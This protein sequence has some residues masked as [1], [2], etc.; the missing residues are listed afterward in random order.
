MRSSKDES[1]KMNRATRIALHLFLSIFAFYS[2]ASA[3][4]IP[5]PAPKPNGGRNSTMLNVDFRKLVSHADLSYNEPASRSEEGLP[6]GNGRMGSLVWTSPSALKFQIN[7]AD[8]FAENSSTHSFPERHG[9]YASGC[10]F[11]DIDFVDYG[12]EVFAGPAFHQDLSVYDALMTLRGNGVSARVLTWNEHDVIAVEVDD[13]REQPSPINIDLRML[14]RHIVQV[15]TR[16][17]SASSKLDI[18]NGR[19]ALTQEFKEG[20][21]YDSSAVVIGMAGRESKSRY[22]NDSTVRLSAAPGKGRF[23]ILIASAASFDPNQDVASRAVTQ[24]EQAAA[25]GFDAM[26]ASNQGWWHDFWSKAFVHLH[27]QDGVADEV[28][29]NYTYFLYLMGITSRGA[30]PPRFGGML[31]YT[32]GDMR[33]WGSQYWWANESCYYNA[34]PAVNRFELMDPMFAMYSGMYDSVSLA[35]AQQ[36]GSKGIFIPEVVWFDGLEKLP[37]DIAAEMRDL[38]LGRKLWEKRSVSFRELAD[39]KQPHS[40]RWNWIDAGS[41]VNGKWVYKDKGAGPYGQVNHIF[42][43]QAKIAHLYW[44]RYEYSQDKV[45]L[46]ERAYP[47]LKGVAEF[48]RNYPNVKKDADGKYHIHDINGHEPIWGA[49]DTLEEVA[50][51]R[52]IVPLAIRASEI[53]DVDPELRAAWREF[54]QNLAPLPTSDL[55]AA[56]GLVKDGGPRRWI[57]GLPPVQKGNLEAPSLAPANYYDL[58]TIESDDAELVKT[59]NATYDAIYPHGVDE[60][61]AINVLNRN[62]AAA[63]HLGRAEDLRH[64]LPNQLNCLNPARDFCD[65]SG[66]GSTRVL[67]NRLTLREGPGATEAER[68]GRVAEALQLALLQSAPPAPGKDAIIHVFPAWPKEWDAQYT[69][70]S[71]GAF[72]MTTSMKQGKVGFVEVQSQAGGECKLRN[73]WGMSEVT[74]YRDGKK[75]ESVRGPLLKFNTRQGEDVVVLRKG[76]TLGQ[77]RQAAVGEAPAADQR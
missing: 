54:L 57:S 5:S 66:G 60:K 51:M 27:S 62:G 30:Y 18:R 26:L 11:V 59:A 67:R 63:A 77:H 35:A 69:L 28:E 33:E 39:T 22:E 42:S 6:T 71:S 1:S 72:L 4:N 7:R 9:D 16:N 38:Y 37:D 56:A 61:T 43:S 65:W 34:L 10:G 44:L 70:L 48:Y 41:W 49:Q 55:P 74:L 14:R 2:G 17:H 23:L 25:K 36:W 29:K 24:L 32:N 76:E 73:P 8:V 13:E 20:S 31:W 53:L 47:M 58:V 15:Q 50:G 12:D 21:Y 46:R 3:Q 52:G 45:W 64:M 68:L 19:I 40:S 75:S